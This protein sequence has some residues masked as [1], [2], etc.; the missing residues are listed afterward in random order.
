MKRVATA[1]V[2]V[3]LVLYLVYW[4]PRLVFLACIEVFALLALWEYSELTAAMGWGVNRP[5]LYLG[6]LVPILVAYLRPN[7][8]FFF[9]GLAF[10][11]LFAVELVRRRSPTEVVPVVAFGVTGWVY[12]ALPFAFLV[13]LRDAT[14]AGARLIL[15]LIFVLSIGDTA[16]YYVGRAIGRRKLAPETSPG[17]TIEGAVASLLASLGAGAWLLRTWFPELPTLHVFALPV[18]LNLA[19]QV[20]DLAES[21]LKRGAGKKD[22]SGLLPGHGGV[23]DRLDA[24]LFGAPAL[25]YYYV[26]ILSKY[27]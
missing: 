14:L 18:V 11:V 10:L 16:A 8:M 4:A 22:S 15:F 12:V 20:G 26:L 7:W 6:G 24:L 13:V 5:V 1:A 3:L 19:G 21:A 17:K 27:F 23:L 2:L 25:W 9:L